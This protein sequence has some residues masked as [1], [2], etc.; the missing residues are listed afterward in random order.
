MRLAYRVRLTPV[1]ADN[2]FSG[3]AQY[4]SLASTRLTPVLADNLFSGVAQ[5]RRLAS[6][7]A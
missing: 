5:Y 4:R 6:I 1:L 7:L 2:L 3:V